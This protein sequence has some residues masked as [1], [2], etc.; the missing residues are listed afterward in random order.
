MKIS[1]VDYLKRLVLTVAAIVY[2]NI[3]IHEHK[4]ANN[5][6][7]AIHTHNVIVNYAMRISGRTPHQ[8][9]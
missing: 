1:I 3:I 8:L 5:L 7:P 6:I 4:L 2:L 9:K